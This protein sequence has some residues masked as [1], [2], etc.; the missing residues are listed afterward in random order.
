MR[1]IAEKV[2]RNTGKSKKSAEKNNAVT[3]KRKPSKERMRNGDARSRNVR[4]I[5]ENMKRNAGK[6]KKS[7]ERNNAVMAGAVIEV[8]AE[9]STTDATFASA[10]CRSHELASIIFIYCFYIFHVIELC[11][12]CLLYTSPSP[13]D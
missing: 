10:L 1:V 3:A 2:K 8:A 5:A 9:V 12:L 6:S 4:L 13:R 11:H 7:A